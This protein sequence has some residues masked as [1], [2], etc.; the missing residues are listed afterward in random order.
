M[1]SR[2]AGM[3]GM[4]AMR[5]VVYN[6]LMRRNSIYVTTML[7]GSYGLTSI[8]FNGTDSLWNTVNKGVSVAISSREYFYT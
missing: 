6:T 7:V 8:Y 4:A 3:T 5:A 1:A 2:E